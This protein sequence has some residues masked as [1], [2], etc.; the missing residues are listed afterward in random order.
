MSNGDNPLLAVSPAT[1]ACPSMPTVLGRRQR[2]N[3]LEM[4]PRKK[5]YALH[6]K[7]TYLAF[8]MTNVIPVASATHLYIVVAILAVQFMHYAT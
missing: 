7:L 6:L 4:G 5:A 3:A 2:E 1:P 8:K